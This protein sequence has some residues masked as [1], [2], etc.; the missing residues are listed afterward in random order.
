[1]PAT[2]IFLERP[3][4]VKQWVDLEYRN[5]DVYATRGVTYISDITLLAKSMPLWFRYTLLHS[6]NDHLSQNLLPC[7][8]S[9]LHQLAF[10][11][12]SSNVGRTSSSGG[13]R[14]TSFKLE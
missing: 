10:A 4:V 12:I 13:G 1:M 2:F 9:G 8:R 3:S 6:D 7:M 5:I 14:A 11:R